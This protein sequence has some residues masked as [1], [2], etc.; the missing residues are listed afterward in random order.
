M[1]NV[2]MVQSNASLWYVC[3]LS[4]QP[5]TRPHTV[6][7]IFGDICHA[8]SSSITYSSIHGVLSVLVFMSA[9]FAQMPPGSVLIPPPT[10]ALAAQPNKRIYKPR[11]NAPP[12]GEWDVQ[13]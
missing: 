8:L 3:R 12:I 1:V 2:S 5:C 11:P 7:I 9:A 13:A 10:G 6:R 4:L